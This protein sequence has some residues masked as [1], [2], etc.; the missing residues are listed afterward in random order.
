[1]TTRKP[2]DFKVRSTRLSVDQ[3]RAIDHFADALFV[4]FPL[5]QGVA[6]VGSSLTYD[7][8]RDVD[9]R[10]VLADDHYADINN[11]MAIADLNALISRWGQQMTGMPIDCQ[12]QALSDHHLVAFE[13]SGKPRHN[14]RGAGTLGRQAWGIRHAA[15]TTGEDA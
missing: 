9:L 13:E 1:M 14:W 6:L 10:V 2:D 3:M 5:M 12:L 8:W 4:M 15:D 7:D 11:A